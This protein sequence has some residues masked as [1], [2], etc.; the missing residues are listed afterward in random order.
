MVHPG[1]YKKKKKGTDSSWYLSEEDECGWRRAHSAYHSGE[2]RSVY[3]VRCPSFPFHFHRSPF[4]PTEKVS[5]LFSST[6]L[7]SSLRL[8]AKRIQ[9]T[10]NSP[11]SLWGVVV[12]LVG[13]W[14]VKLRGRSSP[15]ERTI[16]AAAAAGPSPLVFHQTQQSAIAGEETPQ[17]PFLNVLLTVQGHLL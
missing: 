10:T 8:V 1:K 17:G 6:T 3:L 12:E 7:S 5:C 15:P 11:P 2:V 13:W 4:S 16:G 14:M 9:G